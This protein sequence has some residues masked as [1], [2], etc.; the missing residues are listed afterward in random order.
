M[1]YE[2]CYVPRANAKE[3]TNTTTQ[4]NNVIWLS[5]STSQYVPVSHF[6]L[7]KSVKTASNKV[8]Y[9]WITFFFSLRKL[10]F[11]YKKMY[12][13]FVSQCQT[14]VLNFT[15]PSNFLYFRRRRKSTHFCLVTNG[16][17]GA[18]EVEEGG[19]RASFNFFFK[20]AI[21]A[22]AQGI[23]FY[24]PDTIIATTTIN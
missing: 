18:N 4:C 19:L 12:N 24:P 20:R 5:L 23:F 22:T 8:K 15:Q 11:I 2:C 9:K 13:S 16:K 3:R 17:T 21:L 14:S 6:A 10:T 7:V 1:I